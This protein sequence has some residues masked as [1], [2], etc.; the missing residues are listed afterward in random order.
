MNPSR[1]NYQS[2]RSSEQ[3]QKDSRRFW[4]VTITVTV[5][6]VAVGLAFFFRP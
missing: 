4:I 1:F 3:Q 2:L 5:L 6:L